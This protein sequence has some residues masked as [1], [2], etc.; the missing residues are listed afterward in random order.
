MTKS[1]PV[2]AM[3]FT[4]LM[5][6]GCGP[7]NPKSTATTS[8]GATSAISKKAGFGDS[9]ALYYSENQVFV[10][11]VR[12]HSATDPNGNETTSKPQIGKNIFRIRFIHEADLSPVSA[13]AQ[14]TLDYTHLK[15]KIPEIF[16]GTVERQP[17]GSFLATAYF[18]KKGS[19]VM[20]LRFSDS[21]DPIEPNFVDTYA[22]P[23]TL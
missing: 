4:S 3:T 21:K 23:I 7:M 19:W 20:N 17:D 11:S 2:I 6:F 15:A 16:H 1:L 8:A 18:Q 14:V 10:L 13:G 9:K 22:V 12:L 5:F